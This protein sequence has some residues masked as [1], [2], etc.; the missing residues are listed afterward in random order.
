MEDSTNMSI[1]VSEYMWESVGFFLTTYNP[2]RW[3]I[4]PLVGRDGRSPFYWVPHFTGHQALHKHLQVGR[5]II[6]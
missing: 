3:R 1:A 2:C 5:W 6:T 4:G